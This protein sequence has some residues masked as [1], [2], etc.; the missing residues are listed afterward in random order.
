MGDHR[1][2]IKIEMS[3][4][5]IEDKTDMWINYWPQECCNMDKRVVDFFNSV[6]ERGMKKYTKNTEAYLREQELKAEKELYLKLKDK[7]E[8]KNI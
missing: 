6:Y 5:G 7:Y 4:H 3:F 8:H 2:S 1:A